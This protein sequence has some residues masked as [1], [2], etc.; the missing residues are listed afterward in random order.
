[1]TR[2]L[3]VRVKALPHDGRDQFASPSGTN[4]NSIEQTINILNNAQMKKSFVIYCPQIVA[5][6]R[7]GGLL[8]S[9]LGKNYDIEHNDV[10]L[11]SE[12]AEDLLAYRKADL[13]F[14]FAPVNS[15]SIVC[16]RFMKFSIAVCKDHPASAIAQR[17]R[18]SARKIHAD[19]Q[20]GEWQRVP[21]AVK[22]SPSGT[23]SVSA[24][25]HCFRL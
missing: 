12:S 10:F 2:F 17:S 1:M 6:G 19:A 3:F 4:L 23:Q 11:S 13:V 7:F 20:S 25:T 22:H 24:V 21:A 5:H 9:L 15:R 16:T 14:S 8:S 18:N